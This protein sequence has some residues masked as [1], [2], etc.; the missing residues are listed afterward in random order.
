MKQTVQNLIRR[1]IFE[2]NLAFKAV[3]ML[4]KTGPEDIKLFSCSTE[5]EISTAHK[6]KIPTKKEVSC[7]MNVSCL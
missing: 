3:E 4:H 7:R 2:L 6:N 1:L 5:R